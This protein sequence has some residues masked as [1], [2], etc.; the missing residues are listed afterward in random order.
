VLNDKSSRK[1]SCT[2]DVW[3][4][5]ET[6]KLMQYVY[7]AYLVL[8]SVHSINVLCKFFDSMTLLLFVLKYQKIESLSLRETWGHVSVC[9]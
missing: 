8:M 4:L 3:I 2:L 1:M 5:V 9:Y 6:V 7:Q